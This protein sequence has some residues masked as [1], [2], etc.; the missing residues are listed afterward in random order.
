MID[1]RSVNKESN[2]MCPSPPS[3]SDEYYIDNVGTSLCKRW[4]KSQLLTLNSTVDLVLFAMDGT[5]MQFEN[6]AK[7]CL[8]GGLRDANDCHNQIKNYE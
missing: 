2:G 4:L 5:D 8:I 7:S 6:L 1:L 3:G